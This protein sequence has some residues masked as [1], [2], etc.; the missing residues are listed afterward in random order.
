MRASPLPWALAGAVLG[1][2]LAGAL[3]LF[4]RLLGG[5]PEAAPPVLTV[6]PLPSATP[7]FTPTTPPTQAPPQAET[8]LPEASG[9]RPFSPGQLV[10]I[11]GTGG[12]GL[13]LREAPGLDSPVRLVALESEVFEVIEGPIPADGYHWWR[14]TNPYDRSKE[15]WAAD[16]FLQGLE[17]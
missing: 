10:L 14:L 12:E 11:S 15:G 9:A 16:L 17:S 3:L 5:T 6:I 8:P 4:T 7:T 2:L 1:L 13:R